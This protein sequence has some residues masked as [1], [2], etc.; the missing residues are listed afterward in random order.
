VSIKTNSAQDFFR[1]AFYCSKILLYINP[2]GGNSKPEKIFN[3]SGISNFIRL[4]ISKNRTNICITRHMLSRWKTD[5][6]GKDAHDTSF[7][8]S[9]RLLELYLTVR[10]GRL[11]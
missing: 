3:E 1:E 4:L 5:I 10:G 9:E 2:A 8:I 6:H 11:N 7:W